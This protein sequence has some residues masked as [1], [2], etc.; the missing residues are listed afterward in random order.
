MAI[1]EASNIQTFICKGRLAFS[2][3]DQNIN[4]RKKT[5]KGTP[6]RFLDG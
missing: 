2:L 4:F 5:F 6:K 3:D 1:M